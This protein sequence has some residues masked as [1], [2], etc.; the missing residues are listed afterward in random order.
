MAK[1]VENTDHSIGPRLSPRHISK[2]I[3][4]NFNMKSQSFI[5]ISP[6]RRGRVVIASS[7]RTKDP[8]SNPLQGVGKVCVFLH[9]GF[10]GRTYYELSLYLIEKSKFFKYFNKTSLIHANSYI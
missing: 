2:S 1:I 4:W 8:G 7:S 3:Y 10:V 5:Y 6:W 9:C